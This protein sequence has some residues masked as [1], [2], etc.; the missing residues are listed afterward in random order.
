LRTLTLSE[1]GQT[2]NNRQASRGGWLPTWRKL[3]RHLSKRTFS[4][5]YERI[6][7]A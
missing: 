2:G 3:L 1:L 4:A 6:T 7:P 5:L